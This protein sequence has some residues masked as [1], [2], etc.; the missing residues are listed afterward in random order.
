MT[1]TGKVS[2]A[3]LTPDG[4][5]AV[6]AQ[7]EDGGE[8]LWLLQLE[9]GSQTRILAPRPHEFVG[10]TISADSRFVYASV[11]TNNEIDP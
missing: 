8:S 6:V 7:K 11:F 2:A 9:T 1:T 10:L 3:S 5:F 4:N